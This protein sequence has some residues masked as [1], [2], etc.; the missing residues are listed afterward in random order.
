MQVENGNHKYTPVFK[1]AFLF[2]MIF[3][4]VAYLIFG[5]NE[6]YSPIIRS[7]PSEATNYILSKAAMRIEEGTDAPPANAS[8]E[9]L[10]KWV[11]DNGLNIF[12]PNPAWRPEK[13]FDIKDN[14]YD[15]WGNKLNI[16]YRENFPPGTAADKFKILKHKLLIWSSGPNG[17]NERGHGDDV[18]YK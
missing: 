2:L 11:C 1:D 8:S 7:S 12:L 9:E 4:I 10:R 17:R 16:D 18:V 15:F 5:F 3:G 14:A 13:Y 6:F